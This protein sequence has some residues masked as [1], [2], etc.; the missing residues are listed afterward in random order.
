M[1]SLDLAPA[2]RKFEFDVVG[3]LRVM[4]KLVRRMLVPLEPFGR[5]SELQEPVPTLFAPI[6][7]PRIVGTRLH[8]KLHFH[9]LELAGAEQEVLRIDLIP[10]RFSDLCDPERKLLPRCR[11]HVEKVD[12]DSLCSLRPQVDDVRR[13]FDRA[14]RRLE[15]EVELAGF[16]ECALCAA[17]RATQRPEH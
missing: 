9:L 1:D 11:L 14:H 17:V 8:E 3:V 2:E 15:H 16:G 5:H 10:E 13:I 4:R 12:E 7:E 6:P